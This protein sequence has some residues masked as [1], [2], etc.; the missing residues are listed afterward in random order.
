MNR[1][2]NISPPKWA[3][4][5]LQW[6]CSQEQL[7]IIQGDLYEIFEERLKHLSLLKARMYY[8]KD[9]LDML[10]PFAFKRKRQLTQNN[11][12]MFKNYFKI[13]YRNFLN[14]KVY[15][16][17]NVVGL[18]IGLA[19]SLLIYLYIQDELSYDTM[20]SKA[21]RTYRVLEI[22]ESDGVGERSASNPFAVGPTLI[23]DYPHLIEHSVRLFN[24]QAPS[25]SLKNPDN[26]REFNEAKLFLVDSTFFE[27]FDFEMISGNRET[28]L[29]APNQILLTQAMA[30]KY[31]GKVI[32]WGKFWNFRARNPC[33]SPVFLRIPP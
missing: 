17:V 16:T 12:A 33:K 2:K 6:F 8:I 30:S 11:T 28:A 21:D 13:A 29:D 23:Q 1:Q 15:S 22:F 31:F 9:V 24:F 18:A 10:R 3:D 7:E 25:L 14:Q 4:R 20:H 19:C 26:N 32:P 5:F 27:V